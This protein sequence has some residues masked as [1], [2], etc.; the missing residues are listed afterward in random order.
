MET[1][2]SATDHDW[3]YVSSDDRRIINRIV[4]LIDSHPDQIT[5][6]AT[7]E[8]NDGCIYAR[9]PYSMLK[10]Q[11]KIHRELSDE[12]RAVLSERMK[13]LRNSQ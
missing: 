7:P 1:C 11:P 3:M 9:L 10:I 2:I 5:V 13:S 6:L 12:E 4:K 8:H